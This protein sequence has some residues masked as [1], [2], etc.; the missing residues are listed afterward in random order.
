MEPV[1]GSQPGPVATLGPLDGGSGT[2]VFGGSRMLDKGSARP[3]AGAVGRGRW[4]LAAV[5]LALVAQGGLAVGSAFGGPTAVVAGTAPPAAAPPASLQDAGTSAVSWSGKRSTEAVPAAFGGT[6][7]TLEGKAS[8]TFTFR[9]A[10]AEW[11]A[12]TGPFDGRADVYVDGRRKTRV[13]LYASDKGYQRTAYRVSGLRDGKHTLRVVRT[14]TKSSRSTGRNVTVDAF[15]AL[16]GRAPAAPG[17][18]TVQGVG[19]SVRVGWEGV[20]DDDV[21]G[22]RVTR[23]SAGVAGSVVVGATGPTGRQL[24]DVG[25]PT[26]VR[27]TFGVQALDTSGN[28]SSS[29]AVAL[30]LAPVTPP[31]L[32]RYAGCPAATVT[33]GDSAGLASALGS[34]GPGTVVRLRPGRYTGQ[35]RISVRGTADAPVW[36]CGPRDAVVEGDGPSAGGGVRIADSAHLVLA[37]LSVRNAQKGVSV[38]AST[39]VVLADLAVSE[40][41]EE[42]V[43]LKSGTTD[44]AVVGTTIDRTGLAHPEYGEGLYVGTDHLNWCAWLDCQ[45]DRSD[46]NVL[47]GNTVSRTA[48]EPIE[49]KEGTS[50]GVV[51]GN[52][53]D[54]AGSTVD[55]LVAL[56]GTGWT[57]S[58]NRGTDAGFAGVQVLHREGWG[59]GNAVFGN[60]FDGRLTGYAAQVPVDDPSNVVGCDNR[61]PAQARGISNVACQP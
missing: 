10:G 20:P 49:V 28:V 5:G 6:L 17:G 2:H 41:G 3:R 29:T 19:T 47:Q 57:V 14:G 8:A 51:S 44:S 11:L 13:D 50:D 53:I 58:G 56:K 26:G 21:A 16:D 48:A 27:H 36:V 60:V 31:A 45:P 32:P 34:A 40:I 12:R 59:T 35:V 46:R 42:G 54:G 9:G 43:H 30:T 52:R 37:G 15:R 23:T 55:R 33:V 18:L 22:Y 4:A 39:S 7:V 1:L 61:V 25:V 38:I 24:V